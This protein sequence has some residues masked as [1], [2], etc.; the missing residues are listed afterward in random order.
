MSG[1]V[2]AVGVFA[3]LTVLL[4]WLNS[5][6]RAIRPVTHGTPVVIIDKGQPVADTLRTEHVSL[7]DLMADA[8]TEGIDRFSQ[9]RFAVLETNGRISFFTEKPHSGATDSPAIG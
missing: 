6:F 4:P 2:L 3:L 7:D 9:V 5:R 8:R 1:A